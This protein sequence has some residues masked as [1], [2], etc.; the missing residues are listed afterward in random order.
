MFA[1]V[2]EKQDDWWT[3]YV[4]EISGV[5]TQGAAKEEAKENL[6]EALGMVLQAKR[7]LAPM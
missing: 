2:Y 6:R 5:N 1:A 7:D 3:A 4:E